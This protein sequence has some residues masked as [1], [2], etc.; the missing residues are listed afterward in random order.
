MVTYLYG[1]AVSVC[2]CALLDGFGCV[3]GEL[4]GTHT[5]NTPRSTLWM[6]RASLIEFRPNVGHH[7]HHANTQQ[8]KNGDTSSSSRSWSWQQ[9]Q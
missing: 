3:A 4:G 6:G 7:S 1:V 5:S 9:Q 2:V 8:T